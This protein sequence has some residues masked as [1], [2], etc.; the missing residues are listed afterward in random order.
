MDENKNLNHNPPEQQSFEPK[1]AEQ[2]P[3]WQ[4]ASPQGAS[5]QEAVPQEAAPQNA[6]EESVSSTYA[7][8]VSSAAE[9]SSAE[10]RNTRAP[11]GWTYSANTNQ[12][13][14]WDGSNEQDPGG[15]WQPGSNPGVSAGN[16][17]PSTGNPD[18]STG[19]PQGG[20]W[21]PQNPQ[22]AG[23]QPRP[24][25]GTQYGYYNTVP[26]PQPPHRSQY[27]ATGS[28]AR[29]N[30]SYQW[31]FAKYESADQNSTGK[32]KSKSGRGFKVFLGLVAGVLG[33][34]L[35]AMASFGVY[36]LVGNDFLGLD[37]VLSGE[38][39]SGAGNA[40]DGTPDSEGSKAS[41]NTPSI[42]LAEKPDRK[43]VV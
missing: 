10:Q 2:T 1:P 15:P 19:Y 29:P 25:Y 30:D 13:V 6:A 9:A 27:Q 38:E 28:Y 20:N 37:A 34:C 26:D 24:Q 43:S 3:G 5:P 14:S 35:I 32:K 36:E 7:E 18:A 33:I 41:A 11:S 8:S 21:Q 12:Y 23:S 42:S 16:P 22:Q 40:L 4:E 39:A 31:D 17:S